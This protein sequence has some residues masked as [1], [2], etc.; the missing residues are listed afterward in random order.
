MFGWGC[1]GAASTRP[2][3]R[4]GLDRAA[5]SG[6]GSGSRAV[7]RGGRKNLCLRGPSVDLQP[8][9]RLCG[10]RS[11]A[12]RA[13]RG[14]DASFSWTVPREGRSAAH[15]TPKGTHDSSFAR[16]RSNASA[17][18]TGSRTKRRSLGV[19]RTNAEPCVPHEPRPET[20]DQRA[21][22][23]P[24][25]G[26]CGDH[27]PRQPRRR[28][29]NRR[30]RAAAHQQDETPAAAD[31]QDETPAAADQQDETPASTHQHDEAPGGSAPAGRRPAKP[32][33][34]HILR[35]RTHLTEWS[36]PLRRTRSARPRVDWM[37]S[38]RFGQL[39]VSHSSSARATASSSVSLL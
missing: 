27:T 29:S 14:N 1:A 20:P 32:P 18:V 35:N 19:S 8:Q 13:R 17:W 2:A 39:M 37:F 5:G 4:K 36:L 11:T 26:P 22:Q 3:P 28:T 21:R 7:A 12:E 30:A 31:Q 10:C 34:R 15:P 38:R 23:P 6:G 9:E 33:R 25:R 24:G 16:S